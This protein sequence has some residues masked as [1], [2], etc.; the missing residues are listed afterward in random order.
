MTL[1]IQDFLAQLRGRDIHLAVEGERLRINAPKGALTPALQ[2]ELQQRKPEL[3]SWIRQMQRP[4]ITSAQRMPDMP[5]SISQERIWK[6]MQLVP[7]SARFNMY[8]AFGLHG[9]LDVAALENS[10]NEIVRRH[11]T[12]RTACCMVDGVPAQRISPCTPFTLRQEPCSEDTAL[13]ARLAALIGQPFD[14][15]AGPLH[16][17]TLL[18]LHAQAHVLVLVLHHI[19]ADGWSWDVLLRE[20]SVLYAAC[21]AGRPSPLPKLDIQYADFAVW[22]REWLSGA[23][24]HELRSYWSSQLAPPLQSLALPVLPPAGNAAE[25]RRES[26]LLEDGLAAG[27]KALASSEGVTPFAVH[28]AAFYAALHALSAQDDLI[29]CTPAA[30][31]TATATEPLIGYFNNLLPLRVNAGGKTFRALLRDVHRA[32]HDALDHQELPFDAIAD[33]PAAAHV[34]LARAVISMQG[35]AGWTIELD[36][37]EVTRIELFNQRAVFDVF[38]NVA[39]RDHHVTAWMEYRAGVLDGAQARHMLTAFASALHALVEQPDQGLAD[40]KAH[41]GAPARDMQRAQPA[42]AP[43]HTPVQKQLA[44]LWEAHFDRAPIGIHDDFFALGGSSLLAYRLFGRIA[45]DM[46][47]NLPL[48]TLYQ[49]T[50]IARLAAVIEQQPAHRAWRS[51]VAIQPRGSRPPF[52]GIHGQDGNVLFWRHIVENLDP[53]Q[54]FYG[55]QAQGVD[56]YSK[57][58]SR[59][60]DMAALYLREVQQMQPASPYYLGGFSMGGEIAFEMAQRIVAQGGQVN[61][62]VM[63]DTGN[64]ERPVRAAAVPPQAAGITISCAPELQPLD[65]FSVLKRKL[66]NHM[67]RLSEMELDDQARYIT[68]DLRYRAGRARLKAAGA[69]YRRL[70]RRLPDAILLPSL[71]HAHMT[72]V[73]NYAPQPYAGCITLFRASATLAYSPLNSPMGWEPLALGGV[74]LHLFEATHRIVDEA[75]AVQVGRR[76]QMCLD[77]A[78]ARPA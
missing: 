4:A 62:L 8:L 30:C 72:A 64:P 58:L 36:G 23:R 15:C 60:E 76:L 26:L 34:S 6:S 1:S 55:I 61:L 78:Q 52:F 75:Y 48:A 37:L 21:R 28:L 17:F 22:Q 63:F 11:E 31:R 44:A 12:L 42:Y 16:R 68:Q 53:D 73:L 7:D 47:A 67:R 2:A 20:L 25:S 43:P 49:H 41:T 19:I 38:M 66:V 39:E 46:N 32:L 40:W 18:K 29:I 50:T 71:A 74:D 69:A 65:R 54:P 35:D 59:I 3:M 56:G 10:L 70:N 77:A 13:D 33:L 5:L 14:L 27:V 51:L 57:P 24:M 9:A 45:R